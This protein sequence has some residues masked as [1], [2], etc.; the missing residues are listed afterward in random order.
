MEKRTILA[1][2]LSIIVLLGYQYLFMRPQPPA[3][4]PAA[5]G[6][7]GALAVDGRETPLKEVQPV[8]ATSGA[9]GR[10]PAPLAATPGSRQLTIDG[11]R[12]R[13]VIDTAGG[14]LRSFLLKDYRVEARPD[15][16][17][18]EMVQVRDPEWLPLAG[19]LTVGNRTISDRDLV[20][21]TSAPETMVLTADGA[22][23]WTLVL[24]ADIG[25]GL[26]LEKIFTFRPEAYLFTVHYVLKGGSGQASAIDN[27]SLSW[28][29]QEP[30]N[31]DKRRS[32]VYTGPVALVGGKVF[33]QSKKQKHIKLLEL[34]GA[35]SWIGHTSKYFLA[36]ILPPAAA[37]G[38]ISTGTIRH[39]RPDI[40][41]TI[42]TRQGGST[43]EIFVG[44]KEIETLRA[45][46]AGLE[47]AVD[48]G[49]FGI[50]SR[51][52]VWLL[53]FFHRYIPNYGLD[54]ILLTVLI[55]LLFFPLSQ[56]SYQSMNK[57][58]L[59]QPKLQKIREKYKDDK[60]RLQKEM[61]D[62]YRT[63]KVNPFGGCL[64]I[65]VQIPVFFALYRCLMVAIE[66]RH[67]P[68]YGWITDLSDKDP[69][70]VTPI[71]MGLTMFL[72]QKMTPTTGDP[73]QAKMMLFMPVI[74]TFMFL[75]F[76][77]GLVLYWLVNNV[78][79][80]GQQYLVMRQAQTA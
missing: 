64:P 41:E 52:L 26:R 54:I 11:P 19:S 29:W 33:E 71:L 39:P 77:S 58:K 48:F 63:H 72:Q 57:M 55:K 27:A 46:A 67:A 9:A 68:F 8:P 49:W 80:I 42:L 30:V 53:N 17:L 51:P 50:I 22:A 12:Y 38:E 16:P 60:A 78:L 75:N 25:A 24:S 1:V 69:Y 59:V 3:E 47:Q 40:E 28:C 15:S 76:P 73:M 6:R 4:R 23:E 70:Y 35:V 37:A 18:L 10:E 34:D 61:M 7:T 66:L 13:A 43:F 14:V 5:E 20:Y 31:E 32:Y 56:K 21:A 36:A 65:V 44:P 79:S 45:I 2:A 62:L 74:F